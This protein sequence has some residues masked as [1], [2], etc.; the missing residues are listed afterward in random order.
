[1]RL[2]ACK[3]INS[4]VKAYLDDFELRLRCQ[5][6]SEATVRNYLSAVGSFLNFCLGK[7]GEPAEL[8]RQYIVWG[9]KKSEARTINLHRSAVVKFFYLV[10]G[11]KITTADVERRKQ[12]KKLPK[13]IDRESIAL[14]IS[15][16][17]NVKHKIQLSLIFG[18]GLRLSE[19]AYLKRKNI[20]TTSIP[21]RLR[22]EDTKGERHRLL[23]VP[24]SL[25]TML[26]EFIDGMS[27]DEY[28]FKGADGKQSIDK[29]SV[30][31]VV[32]ASFGRIGIRAHPHMLR[33]SFATEQIRSGQNL[34]KVQAWLGHQSIKTTQIY[35]T[36]ADKDLM[37]STDLL[38]N[39]NY[40][41]L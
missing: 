12:P 20:I 17:Y 15:K 41:N 25:R 14:A 7:H 16:T 13:V 3:M 38:A 21:F 30:Q 11:I 35:V 5:T 27:H 31:K 8:L 18:C 2:G 28:V 32:A 1:M 33:H 19:V 6:R 9:L 37:E 36:L 40:T 39:G 4:K 24:E 10:K 26:A 34:F 22:L 23:P 29:R